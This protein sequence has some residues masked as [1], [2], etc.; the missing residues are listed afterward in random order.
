M[1]NGNTV[2]AAFLAGSIAAGATVLGTLPALFAHGLS[3]R[4]QDTL[5]GFSAGAQM[6]LELW[7]ARPDSF[8]GLVLLAGAPR[9]SRGDE[10]APGRT[11]ERTTLTTV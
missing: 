11:P 3:R 8:G 10:D 2:Q 5:L 7:A 9:F 1:T 6:A 4:V